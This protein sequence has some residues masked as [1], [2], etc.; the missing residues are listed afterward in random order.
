MTTR[1]ELLDNLRTAI[2]ILD[3]SYHYVYTNTA[4]IDLLG[5]SSDLKDISS[6][7]SEDVSLLS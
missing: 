5:T 6:L 3:S 4:A 7:K 2:I 1:Y